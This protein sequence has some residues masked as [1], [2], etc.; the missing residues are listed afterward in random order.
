LSGQGEGQ[1]PAAHAEFK[2]WSAVGQVGDV[3][4]Y[5]VGVSDAGESD[6]AVV[7]VPLVVNRGVPVAVSACG[8]VLHSY[9]LPPTYPAFQDETW[10]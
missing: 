5:L 6:T 4:G 9:S 2:N 1:A 8:V 7:A 3:G 10:G